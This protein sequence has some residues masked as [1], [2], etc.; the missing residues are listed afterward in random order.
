MTEGMPE[1]GSEGR[2][3]AAVPQVTNTLACPQCG[4]DN[5]LPSGQRL[6]VCAYCGATLFVDRGGLISHYRIPR[7]LDA[8]QAQE[9]ARRWMAGNLTVKGLDH[10]AQFQTTTPLLFPMWMFRVHR[11]GGEV[12]R[13]EPAAPTTEPQLA[14][15]QVPA[16]Q[17]EPYVHG[18]GEG[19]GPQTREPGRERDVAEPLPVQVPLETARAWLAQREGPDVEVT[20]TAVVHLPLWECS[21]LYQGDSYKALV[22]GS[23]GAVLA[24]RFPTK[25]EGPFWVV[26]VLG[27]L[28]F[29]VEGLM[30][31]NPVL[32]AGIYGATAVPLFLL[33][34][35]VARKV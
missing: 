26:A 31:G 20:E 27:I 34:Y 4:A 16:G 3:G 9:A 1:T 24:S 32:K 5:E 13:V 12:V 22:D 21:Y 7:L 14:D 19:G 6:L 28:I 25:S 35:W 2:T 17:L 29:L 18:P 11:P 23:T 33:A 10:K 30:T 15:L 8:A